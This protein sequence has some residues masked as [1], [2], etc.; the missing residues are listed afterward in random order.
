MKRVYTS[1]SAAQCNL[2]RS[3]LEANGV[4]CLVKKE[5]LSGLARMVSLTEAWPELWVADDSQFDEARRIVQEATKN[6]SQSD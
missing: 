4:P 5:S 2:L 1:P 6:S 3:L